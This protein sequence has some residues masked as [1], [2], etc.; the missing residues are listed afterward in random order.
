MAK[1]FAYAVSNKPD[2]M[3]VNPTLASLARQKVFT[4]SKP[5]KKTWQPSV[6]SFSFRLSSYLNLLFLSLWFSDLIKSY[7]EGINQTANLKAIICQLEFLPRFALAS[8]ITSLVPLLSKG[9]SSEGDDELVITTL[10]SLR[11]IC[12][13]VIE[14]VYSVS[15]F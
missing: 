4:I 12:N 8:E 9:L 1:M 6:E 13:Q 11:D 15:S 10:T 14:F 3:E 5:G 7:N 2:F